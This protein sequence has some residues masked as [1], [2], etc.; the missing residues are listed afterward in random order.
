[1]PFH[2]FPHQE[3]RFR[4]ICPKLCRNCAFPQNFHTR[5]LGEI[6]IFYAVNALLEI[7]VGIPDN[8]V[9][10][11]KTW[12]LLQYH[13][14]QSTTISLSLLKVG[15]PY[16]SKK[17]KL[18]IGKFFCE[19]NSSQFFQISPFFHTLREFFAITSIITRKTM[20]R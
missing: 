15:K 14:T 10:V 17:S 11:L 5:K 18:S 6:T 12:L 2:K 7:F 13:Q 8:Q 9:L 20:P 3:I 4:A 16:F 19:K 1:M